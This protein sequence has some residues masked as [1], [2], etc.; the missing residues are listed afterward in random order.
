MVTALTARRL[1]FPSRRAGFPISA[2]DLS[3]PARRSDRRYATWCGRSCLARWRATS[4]MHCCRCA[5]TSTATSCAGAAGRRTARS[6]F[7][8]R[9]T[10]AD[11]D[12]CLLDQNASAQDR[13][14]LRGA[15]PV[16]RANDARLL[17]RGERG[18]G[19]RSIASTPTAK[20][21]QHARQETQSNQLSNL[22]RKTHLSTP[23]R[24]LAR[25]AAIKPPGSV[26]CSLLSDRGCGYERT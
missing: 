20:F 5:I 2:L 15:R 4:C 1:R 26:R 22:N 16:R 11:H 25:C 17:G 24:H 12:C 21:R 7:R 13:G 14:R 9:Y 10:G 23:T 18:S 6:G 3:P 8:C 19:D